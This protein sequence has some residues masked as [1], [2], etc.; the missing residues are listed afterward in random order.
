MKLLY[1]FA[2]ALVLV[3]TGCSRHYVMKLSNGTQIITASKPVAKGGSYYFKD[4]SGAEQSI[5][6]G[7]VR[8]IAPASGSST[9]TNPFRSSGH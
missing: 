9:E 6:Q 4:A 1:L 5:S 3:L 7:R 8:E 2:L